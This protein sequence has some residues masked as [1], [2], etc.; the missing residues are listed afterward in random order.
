MEELCLTKPAAAYAEQIA[1]YRQEFLDSG[2]EL[3]GG[4]MLQSYSSVD[5]WLEWVQTLSNPETC[6]T[7]FVVS[8]QY[9]CVRELD[10]CVVGMI[11]IRYELNDYLFRIGGHIG[12]SVRPSERQKG[13]AKKQLALM[14]R[15][16]KERGLDRAMVSC[17]QE[18]EASRRTILS[19]GGVMENEVWDQ[20]DM[21]FVQRYWIDLT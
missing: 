16:A 9:L 14:L 2:D 12:Y 7:G 3:H 8:E 20:D 15:E 1:S 18:N 10:G 21:T 13:Y 11:N 17:N 6:P 5:K 19:N 4:S